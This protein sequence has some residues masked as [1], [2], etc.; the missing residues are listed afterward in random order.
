M[1]TPSLIDE[2]IEELEKQIA[3]VNGA[4]EGKYQSS[5]SRAL[6]KA[7]ISL[8]KHPVGIVSGAY[9]G[10]IVS[11]AVV[12]A[13][14]PI[15]EHVLVNSDGNL[16]KKIGRSVKSGFTN[17]IAK[18]TAFGYVLPMGLYNEV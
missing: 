2:R 6:K 11:T 16:L 12:S 5:R 7:G 9:G 17:L 1:E 18:K 15:G 8:A 4:S 13:T 14:A 3:E 10:P